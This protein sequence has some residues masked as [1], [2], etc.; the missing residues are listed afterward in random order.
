MTKKEL[1]AKMEEFIELQDAHDRDDWYV[2][3]QSMARIVLTQ[4]ADHL[5]LKLNP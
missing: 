3:Q 2:T 4:F 1:A 5:G